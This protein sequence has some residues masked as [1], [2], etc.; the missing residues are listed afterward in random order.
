LS[1]RLHSRFTLV[2]F[3]LVLIASQPPSS[4]DFSRVE[5]EID[6]TDSS[7]GCLVFL[8]FAFFNASTNEPDVGSYEM[9]KLFL[10]RKPAL[11]ENFST[12]R[13]QGC[14]HCVKRESHTV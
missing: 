11:T 7:G 10:D 12:K 2:F 9:V 4:S 3:S 1:C 14:G 13:L 5:L 6:V 8:L